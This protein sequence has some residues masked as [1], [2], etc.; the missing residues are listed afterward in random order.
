MVSLDNLSND[1]ESDLLCQMVERPL[2]RPRIL[3]KSEVPE[4]EWR[5]TTCAT[6]NNITVVGDLVRRTFICNLDAVT[7]QPETRVFKNDPIAMVMANRG[8]YVAAALTIGRAYICTDEKVKCPPLGSYGS[9][10]RFVREPLLWLEQD[11]PIKSI[12]Q[13]RKNDPKRGAA[14]RLIDQ[15]AEHLGYDKAY[16]TIEVINAAKDAEFYDLLLEH[17][18]NARRE[19]DTRRLGTWLRQ[20]KGKVHSKQRIVAHT[21]SSSWGNTWKLEKVK[22]K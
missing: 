12:E 4:C 14:Q 18:G 3:G 20:I 17:A 7:E 1:L 15:W 22:E 11:D 21:E 8:K 9:W 6:G 13:A 16:K 19:V 10:S 2:V 5:G